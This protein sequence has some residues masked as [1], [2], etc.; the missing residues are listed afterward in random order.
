MQWSA[1][2]DIRVK[3]NEISALKKDIHLL[4]RA[5]DEAIEIQRRDLTTAFEQIIQQ[6]EEQIAHR[7]GEL[8]QQIS[9]LDQRFEKLTTENMSLK[10]TVRELKGANERNLEEIGRLEEINRQLN[11]QVEDCI[12]S[13]EQIEDSLKRQVANLQADL[14]RLQ[15][16][17]NREKQDL[18][19]QIER[20]KLNL[21]SIVFKINRFTKFYLSC[22]VEERDF[23][24]TRFPLSC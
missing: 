13:K 7:E 3:N 6:R 19:A 1:E 24:G 18:D 16:Q 23:K 4:N 9:L 22:I 17:R 15:D 5:K 14:Q 8:A 20:V 2:E 21:F 11:Y 10:S 12:R